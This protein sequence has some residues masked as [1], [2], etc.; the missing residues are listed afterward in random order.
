MVRLQQ[1]RGCSQSEACRLL[2]INTA[3]GS[4][5]LSV[6]KGYPEDL[7]AHLGDGDGKV[8]I[9][10]AYQLSRLKDE[11]KVRDLTAKVI[12]GL[13]TRDSVDAI[14]SRELSA[15]RKAKPAKPVRIVCG[16]V[17]ATVTGNPIEALKALHAKLTD[18]FRRVERD[19]ALA[20]L[21]PSLLK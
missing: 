18:V 3:D 4:K 15:G 14:V 6:L 1:L 21:L 20:D 7:H 11:G 9:T 8:P 2:G 13:L 5:W 19:P 17:T 12:G 16:N 10:V